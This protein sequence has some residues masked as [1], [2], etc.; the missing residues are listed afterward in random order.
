MLKKWITENISNSE[1]TSK[2]KENGKYK[3]WFKQN[4]IYK[5]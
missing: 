1:E 5:E 2:N 3:N 4:K